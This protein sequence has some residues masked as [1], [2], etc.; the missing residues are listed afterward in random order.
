M[1]LAADRNT[2][3]D[4]TV[5]AYDDVPGIVV[6]SETIKPDYCFWSWDNKIDYYWVPSDKEPVKVDFK[7]TP[8][9][10]YGYQDWVFHPAKE[11]GLAIVTGGTLGDQ[12]TP[13]LHSLP[14]N[15]GK[16]TFA[17]AKLKTSEDAIEF[18]KELNA[19]KVKGIAPWD[20]TTKSP[21]VDYGK[22]APE[23]VRKAEHYNGFYYSD[24]Y[25]NDDQHIK[26]W[27]SNFHLIVGFPGDKA[28]VDKLHKNGIRGILYVN[29][30]EIYGSAGGHKVSEDMD[31]SKHPNW[32]L[33][34]E[35][36]KETNPIGVS[37]TTFRGFIPPAC[38]S[39][40]SRKMQSGM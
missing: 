8:R 31:I 2:D 25:Y 21:K 10:K 37:P 24:S 15:L 17:L 16:V 30:M 4:L 11:G 32:I 36:G 38:I 13:Y 35:N 22:P 28:T 26:N 12:G 3:F 14:R 29:F 1:H 9:E 23:W 18:R 27:F 6:T 33:I 20:D 34:D 5:E 39:K 19:H 40:T 7:E